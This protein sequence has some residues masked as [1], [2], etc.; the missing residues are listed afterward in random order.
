MANAVKVAHGNTPISDFMTQSPHSIGQQQS[1]SKAAELMRKFDIRHLPVLHGGKVVGLLSRRDLLLVETLPGVDPKEVTVE[2]A[3][4]P[5][6]YTV[7]P[8]EPLSRVASTMAH[9]KLG[10]AV[11]MKGNELVGLFTTTDAL[12]VL[13]ENLGEASLGDALAD[14]ADKV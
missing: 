5:A 8:D 3:M 11:I 10:T 4:S 14:A 1:L 2:E 7:Q 12:R 13:A 9:N 6:P